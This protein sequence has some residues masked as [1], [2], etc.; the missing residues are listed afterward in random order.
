MR[1]K[2]K[3]GRRKRRSGRDGITRGEL[4]KAAAAA[5]A[6]VTLGGPAAAAKAAAGK[7]A[8]ARASSRAANIGGM[9]VLLFLTDQQ[10]AV[11]HFPPGWARRNLPGFTQLQRTG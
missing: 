5:A 9:N 2:T 7:P 11:Q 4:L 10:R 6:A 3:T 8:R 1:R